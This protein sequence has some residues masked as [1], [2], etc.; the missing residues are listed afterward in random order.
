MSKVR[1]NVSFTAWLTATD[2]LNKSPDGISPVRHR[3]QA[4]SLRTLEG[5]PDIG[6]RQGMDEAP[7][8]KFVNPCSKDQH[9]LCILE[10][11]PYFSQLLIIVIVNIS[12]AF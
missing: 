3:S 1:P 2:W 5:S 7:G 10:L 9:S 6:H 11:P 12:A 4:K 8:Q